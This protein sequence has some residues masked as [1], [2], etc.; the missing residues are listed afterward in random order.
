MPE[1]YRPQHKHRLNYMPW[2]Y[3]SLKPAHRAWAEDWQQALQAELMA[4]ETVRIGQQCFIAENAHLF[5]ERGR[6]IVLGDRCSIAADN[7][8]HGPITLGA[9]VSIN[10]GC[11][12]DGGSAGIHIG[13]DTRIAHGCSVY[14]FN[15]GMAPNA[16]IHEQPVTSRGIH[17]GKDVWI[18]ARACIVDGVRIGDHAVIGAGSVVT[19]DVPDWAIA[20]GNPARIIGDRRERTPYNRPDQE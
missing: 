2:L 4:L 5:A 9:G 14:A 7:V 10:H 11:S 17:I 6:D 8:L 18:G 16:C 3:F 12:L 15:H 20:A 1:R 19:H 13:S